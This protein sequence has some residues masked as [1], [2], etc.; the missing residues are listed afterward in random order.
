M[1]I[2]CHFKG[3]THHGMKNIRTTTHG[4]RFYSPHIGTWLT[5]DPLGVEVDSNV[6]AFA[7]NNPVNFI[8]PA[9]L[10]RIVA[11]YPTIYTAW[12]HDPNRYITIYLI[13]SASKNSFPVQI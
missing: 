9:K 12:K 11:G 2:L 7:G 4:Y 3:T 8:D 10:L 1:L 13:F 5:M 6:Y